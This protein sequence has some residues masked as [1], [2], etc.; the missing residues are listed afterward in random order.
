[1]VL[2]KYRY[3]LPRFIDGPVNFCVKH[4]ISPNSITVFG[5]LISAVAGICYAFPTIF[6]YNYFA[7][8]DKFWI[9]FASI[10][11][12]LFFF[13]AYLDV[14]DGS[15]ARKTNNTTK[16]GG[17]L[18]STLDRVSDSIIILG[19]I[20]GHMIWPWDFQINCLIGFI[21]MG[22]MLLIS[23]TRSRAEIEGVIMKGI[24][25]M[26]RAERVFILLGGYIV[27]W[28]IFAIQSYFLQIEPQNQFHGFFP[29][30][31]IIFTILCIQT[32]MA[33]ISWA[34]K[35]LNNKMPEKV[36]EM[37]EEETKAKVPPKMEDLNEEEKNDQ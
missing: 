17:F 23:Y 37:L 4:H 11:P 12:I 10:P 34:D 1:M 16:F 14:L 9:F 2:N 13:S 7:F 8:T 28:I 6:L 25:F 18:D 3:L 30:F 35:W 27:E 33:R 22:T 19:L 29:I 21:A 32:L 36:A 15:V 24:G 31:F 5:F 26:E 20:S